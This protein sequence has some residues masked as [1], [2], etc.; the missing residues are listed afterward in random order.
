MNEESEEDVKH[1]ITT[2]RNA[3]SHPPAGMRRASPCH[4]PR[5]PRGTWCCWPCR[6]MRRGRCG[7]SQP[8]GTPLHFVRQH[9]VLKKH[10][11]PGIARDWV[12]PVHLHLLSFHHCVRRRDA[13]R[14]PNLCN[15]LVAEDGA[16]R[17]FRGRKHTRRAWL[18]SPRT[19]GGHLAS[20]SRRRRASHT[21]GP[22]RA[23]AQPSSL[24]DW[25]LRSTVGTSGEATTVVRRPGS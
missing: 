5:R 4:R 6:Q 16:L 18:T 15:D 19:C 8:S 24:A 23:Q 7:H 21:P 3:P 1:A 9:D 17:P 11:L 14:G 2:A 10:R 13:T 12:R 20:S 25:P 22:I